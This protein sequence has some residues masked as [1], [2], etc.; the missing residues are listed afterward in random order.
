MSYE[1]TVHRC[2]DMF[3]TIGGD[4]V[5]VSEPDI[6]SEQFE[7]P[8]NKLSEAGSLELMGH[9]GLVRIKFE[10]SGPKWLSI[11]TNAADYNLPPRVS[12]EDVGITDL[13]TAENG[14]S[15]RGTATFLE[16]SLR[17]PP[18]SPR[19]LGD[20]KPTQ[21]GTFSLSCPPASWSTSRPFGP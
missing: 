10:D 5:A 3:G 6:V 1:V 20:D 17:T 21:N 15:T 16:V 2:S 11:S 7:L 13:D 4:G 9:S 8:T 12:A 14:E 18:E 19:Q